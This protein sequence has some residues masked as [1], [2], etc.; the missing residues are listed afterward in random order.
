MTLKT[1]GG[2][3]LEI[4]DLLKAYHLRHMADTDKNKKVQIISAWE[5][6]NSNDIKEIFSDFL[7]P[8]IRWQRRESGLYYSKNHIDIFKGIDHTSLYNVTKFNKAAVTFFRK[9]VM[10]LLIFLALKIVLNFYSL[11]IC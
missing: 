7:F 9:K 1:P 4:H 3:A 5:N 2:K 11:K 8:I 6:E 10:I